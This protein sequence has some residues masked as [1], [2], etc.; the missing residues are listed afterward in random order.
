[1]TDLAH[2]DGA[3]TTLFHVALPS[4]SKLNWLLLAVP[5]AVLANQQHAQ[6]AAFALSMLAIMP[7][8]HMMGKA[9]EEIALR[10]SESLGGLI[11]ATF[12]NA[13][14]MII[15]VFALLAAASNPQVADTMVLVV[16]ASLIGSILGNLL[17]VMGLSLLY[18]GLKHKEQTF[19]VT[20]A[21]MN[22]SLLLLAVMA[23]IVPA[24]IHTSGG[25][26]G[27][28]LVLSRATA[29]ILLLL[30]G[31]ALLFQLGT[32]AEVFHTNTHSEHESPTMSSKDAWLL[33]LVATAM[34][35]WMAHLL[36][37][38][39]ESAV[40]AWHMPQLFI[41]VILLPF[42]GNAA[43]HFAAVLMAGKNKM[44]LSIG[45]AIGSSVQ[46]ALLVAPVMVLVGWMVGVD[47]GLEFGL[48]E[49]AATFLSVLVANSLLSDGRT[50]WLEG[51]MLLGTYLILAVAFLV[52]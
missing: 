51:A 15:A 36:V 31:L 21:S 38:N 18:G 19:S 13:V 23:L 26:V 42:F 46:I 47:L 39:L 48:L 22:G 24:A 30:Y 6:A 9:T 50:N 49:T 4:H 3:R 27:D 44:D 28:V 45:I 40:E 12:G 32:H 8:A 25:G 2:D 37:H 17:L 14:E 34:V 33:L 7:L 1:M 11:N 43:E 5:A 10:T 41:G 16:Q 20:A 52:M 29:I 35:S